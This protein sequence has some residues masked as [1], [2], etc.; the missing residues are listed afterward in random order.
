MSNR[1]TAVVSAYDE[2]MSVAA[3]VNTWEGI[4]SPRGV[5]V[6]T[7]DSTT[8]GDI[9]ISASIL[10]GCIYISASNAAAPISRHW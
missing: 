4:T 2:L 1:Q 6:L 5:P 10:G 8:F 9:S 7:R 3:H